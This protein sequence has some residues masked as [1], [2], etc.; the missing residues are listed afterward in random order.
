MLVIG[1]GQVVGGKRGAA[2]LVDRLDRPGNGVA[3]QF[4]R[5]LQPLAMRAQLEDVPAIGTF[6]LENGAAVMQAVAEDVQLG[7]PPGA[8]M[9][10]PPDHTVAVIERNERHKGCFR[11]N[12]A[13]NGLRLCPACLLSQ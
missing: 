3:E 2:G 5:A 9:A 13:W 6:P 11:N 7:I 12:V 4:R 1:I 10:V 8:E